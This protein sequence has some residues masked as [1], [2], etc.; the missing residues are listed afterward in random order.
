MVEALARV[1]AEVRIVSLA[2]ETSRWGIDTIRAIVIA[3]L[4]KLFSRFIIKE[5]VPTLAPVVS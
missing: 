1:V 5:S 3:N 2:G 4:T